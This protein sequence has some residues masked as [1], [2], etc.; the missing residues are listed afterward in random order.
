D[1]AWLPSPQIQGV[2]NLTVKDLMVPNMK[3]WDREKIESIFPLHTAKRI[4]EV[5][6]FDMIEED[7][8]LWIDSTQ[9][10]YSVKSGYKLMSNIAGTANVMY[11]QDDWQ[12]LWTI[13]APPKAKHLLW[14]ISRGCLPTRMRLQTRHVP[15]PSSC[16]LCNHDSEDE[17][18]V[19][20]DCDVSIQARQTA[21]LEQLLQ[22]QIQQHQ[23]V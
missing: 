6:L 19:F 10:Q 4:L 17:W 3:V 18:H 8:L 13:L 5:P 9:G 20:F 12:S 14:R 11:Q 1:G 2:Q 15:C 22:N 16:P 21:G 7:K 23:N